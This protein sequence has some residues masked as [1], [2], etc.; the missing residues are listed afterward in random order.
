SSKRN[1][2]IPTGIESLATDINELF[3]NLNQLQDMLAP[4]PTEAEHLTKLDAGTLHEVLSQMVADSH[5]L[6]TLPERTI[7]IDQLIEHGLVEIIQYY[8]TIGVSS[9]QVTSEL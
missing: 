8:Q 5:T 3:D 1:P 4:A 2:V 6:H 9:D 7:V